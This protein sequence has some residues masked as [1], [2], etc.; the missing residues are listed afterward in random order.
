MPALEHL[1]IFLVNASKASGHTALSPGPDMT[2]T[3]GGELER[4]AEGNRI[5]IDVFMDMGYFTGLKEVRLSHWDN[6]DPQCYECAQAGT[7]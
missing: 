6:A 7:A 1:A 4:D 2:L 5:S 3:C